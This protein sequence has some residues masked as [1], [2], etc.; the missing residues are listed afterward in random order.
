MQNLKN[1]F[2]AQTQITINMQDYPSTTKLPKN[3]CIFDNKFEWHK[4]TLVATFFTIS[5]L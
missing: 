1:M 5:S 2:T 4:Q 3:S